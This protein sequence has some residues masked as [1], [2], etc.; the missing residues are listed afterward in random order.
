MFRKISLLKAVQ[1][2]ALGVSAFSGLFLATPA[3][4]AVPAGFTDELFVGEIDSVTSMA[5]APDGRLFACQQG[6]QVRVIKNGSLLPAPFLNISVEGSNERG[7]LGIAFDPQFAT[8][9]YVYF[10]YTSSATTRNRVSRFR[11]STANPDLAEAGSEQILLD[12][13]SAEG[14][15]NGGAINFGTD[16]ML[17]VGV[18]DGHSSSNAQSLANLQGKILRLNPA[19]FPNIIPPNNPFVNNSGVRKEIWAYGLRN[20]FTFGVDPA[21]GKIH[22]NDV[23]QGTWEEVNLGEPGANFGW[24]ACEGNCSN[25]AFKNPVY[26]YNHSGGACAITGGVFYRG[27]TFP[28]DYAGSYFFSDFCAGFIRRLRA[29]NTVAEFATD[30]AASDIDVGPDGSLYYSVFYGGEIRRI[31]AT[32]GSPTTTTTSTT[33]STTT[34]RTTTTTTSSST[35]TTQPQAEDDTPPV[36]TRVSGSIGYSTAAIRWTTDEAADS[37]VVY[38]ST[39]TR[40]RVFLPALVTAHRVELRRLRPSTEYRIYV[41]SAD[42][43]GNLG[44]SKTYRFTTK[45]APV[46]ASRVRPRRLRR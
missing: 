35:T 14:Y 36:I 7:L 21:N 20:P 17:Y 38:W 43:L 24:P 41:R 9:R 11:A 37:E 2:L 29:N 26:A 33:T 5:F 28:A 39:G 6:G 10:Y 45:A 22:I 46:S 12:V 44:I 42:A 27:A 1:G 32:G 18:G 30:A 34:T 8:N 23:G 19:G 4:A 25:T 16:G 31:R 15:H 13:A 3:R 40:K